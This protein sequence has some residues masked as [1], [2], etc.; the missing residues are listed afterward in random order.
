M[1]HRP[2]STFEIPTT[3]SARIDKSGRIVIPSELRD[4]LH[5]EPGDELV[6]REESG[7]VTIST[8]DRALAEAQDYFMSLVEPGVSV[9]D[10]LIAE[11]RAE[12]AREAAEEAGDDE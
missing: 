1:Q 11:R 6:V 5:L 8:Y 10:E 4:R 12:A 2:G 7:S 3:Y 9:V